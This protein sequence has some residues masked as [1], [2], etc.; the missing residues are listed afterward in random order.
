MELVDKRPSNYPENIVRPTIGCRAIMERS[1]RMIQ[2]ILKEMQDWKEEVR[3]HSVKLLYQVILHSEMAIIAKFIEIFPILS[4]CCCDKEKPIVAEARKSSCLLGN[5]LNFTDWITPALD[6]LKKSTNLGVLICFSELFQ[7]AHVSVKS[8]NIKEILQ[9]LADPSKCQNLKSEYQ[10]E[11]L[12]LIDHLCNLYLSNEHQLE[13]LNLNTS[14]TGKI[15]QLFYEIILKIIALSLSPDAADVHEKGTLI[16]SKLAKNPLE[17]SE[18]HG[19]YLKNILES[20][21]DL[22]TENSERAEPI[23]LL[24]GLLCFC[25]FQHEYLETAKVCIKMVMENSGPGAKIK[26]LSGI[27]IVRYFF[28]LELESL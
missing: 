16:L 28:Q 27:S 10:S 18:L 21:E 6:E 5:L 1:I 9:L 14:E 23:I 11:L 8:K 26:I 19:K 25:G 13:N 12:E 3:F 15:E 7:G 22:D 17:L 2:C 20:I 4:K 24:Y